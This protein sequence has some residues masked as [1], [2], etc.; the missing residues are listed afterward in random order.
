MS[1]V[2]G[3]MDP[4]EGMAHET[5]EDSARASWGVDR[6]PSALALTPVG[7]LD[8]AGRLAVAMVIEKYPPFVG[9]AERQ[10]Q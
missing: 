1:A 9:G 5:P 10:A 4:R 2:S 6:R 7:A 8:R 3:A